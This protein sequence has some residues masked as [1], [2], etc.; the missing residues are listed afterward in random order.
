MTPVHH[1]SR[2]RQHIQLSNRNGPS[3]VMAF[4]RARSQHTDLHSISTAIIPLTAFE[5][6][7][8]IQKI[9]DDVECER[10][11]A[12]RLGT[13][14]APD[15]SHAIEILKIPNVP[16]QRPSICVLTALQVQELNKTEWIALFISYENIHSADAWSRLDICTINYL[17]KKKKL[18][19]NTLNIVVLSRSRSQLH[20]C[21][22]Y[23]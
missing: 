2:V 5:N 14:Y 7:L 9:G 13:F 8:Y 1:Y 11:R 17:L 18:Y 3:Y 20:A 4:T 22:M 15:A 12:T 10:V 19:R 16:T 6:D 21:N 23:G